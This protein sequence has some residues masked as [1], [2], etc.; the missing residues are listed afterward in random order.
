M[1]KSG[2]I[3][4]H[5]CKIYLDISVIRDGYNND[6]FFSKCNKFNDCF[7]EEFKN[8]ELVDEYCGWCNTCLKTYVED[9]EKRRARLDSRRRRRKI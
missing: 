9:V 7:K 3:F 1:C 6:P 8:V 5:K 4:C 2:K